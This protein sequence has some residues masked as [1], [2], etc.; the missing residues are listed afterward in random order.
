MGIEFIERLTTRSGMSNMTASPTT[1]PEFGQTIR[2][3]NYVIS[4]KTSGS[5]GALTK[6]C[7]ARSAP[8]RSRHQDRTGE[9]TCTCTCIPHIMY[10]IIAPD[11]EHVPANRNSGIVRL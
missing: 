11:L 9:D 5:N 2:P 6:A 10:R 1:S 8:L 7:C 3:A 4:N